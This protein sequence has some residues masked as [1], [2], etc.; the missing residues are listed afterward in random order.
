MYFIFN[1]YCLLL[2]FWGK[3]NFILS[4]IFCDTILIRISLLICLSKL[5][6]G[7]DYEHSVQLD[8]NYTLYWDYSATN[9]TGKLVVETD[10]WLSFGL[11]K[12]GSLQDSDLI[13]A[14]I[15]EDAGTSRTVFMDCYYKKGLSV[16]G[17][18][19]QTWHLVDS[20]RNGSTL[21]VEFTRFLI[22]QHIDPLHDLNVEVGTPHVS[23]AY[24]F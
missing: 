17:D 12:R 23:Y 7:I 15:E 5:A 18:E 21:T 11:T 10:G 22:L 6:N 3:K 16:L 14:W 19:L 8:S 1:I 4:M 9:L 2:R 20:T 24:G 13:V